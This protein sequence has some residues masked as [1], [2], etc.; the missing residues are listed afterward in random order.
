M[1]NIDNEF[2]DVVTPTGPMRT[3][4]F[5][6]R[7]EGRFPCVAMFPEI[8][9]ITHQIRRIAAFVAV[10]GFIVAVPEIFHESLPCGRALPY[11]EEGRA[12]GRRL[13][14][15][16]EWDAYDADIA[17]LWKML[18]AHGRGTGQLGAAGFCFGGHLAVRAALSEDVMACSAF[19][20][21]LLHS[22]R[23][24]RNESAETLRRIGEARGELAFFVGTEDPMLPE[25]GRRQILSSLGRSGINFRWHEFRAGHAFTRDGGEDYDQ[26]LTRDCLGET[27]ALF[28]RTLC[29]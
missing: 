10:H 21:T 25:E 27:V 7:A 2:T 29:H 4:L 28:R 12:H 24:E 5:R 18:K 11:S 15:S 23:P 13:M 26:E 14:N 1:R 8:F 20:P 3:Y 9:Q 22:G 6:P 16:K 19:Y 17:A